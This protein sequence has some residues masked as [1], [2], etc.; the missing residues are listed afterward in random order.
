MALY[1]LVAWPPAELAAWVRSV[2]R[3]HGLAAFGAPHLS[4]RSPFEYH[5][6]EARL[7]ERCERIAAGTRA[8]EVTCDEVVRFPGMIFLNLRRTPELLAVHERTLACL[9]AAPTERDGEGFLPHVTLALGV[10]SWAEEDTWRAVKDLRPPVERWT[11]RNVALTRERSG[12][13]LELA[14]YPLVSSEL[15]MC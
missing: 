14:R 2:Q 12:D 5:G 4:L 10:C 8:F 1:S 11:V 15:T 13:V 9:P 7:L 3:T 6:D